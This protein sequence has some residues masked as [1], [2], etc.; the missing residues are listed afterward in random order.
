MI[1]YTVQCTVC[2]I[3]VF[4][5]IVRVDGTLIFL[6]PGHFIVWVSDHLF[7]GIQDISWETGRS[8]LW[9]FTFWEQDHL[10]S[11]IWTTYALG[12]RT[13]EKDS[14]LWEPDHL[15]SGIR[16]LGKCYLGIEL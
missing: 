11:G 1:L 5:K 13:W 16:P 14:I 4:K 3:E 6:E 8:I 9:D 7:F 2:T 12:Y 10:Y 15:S